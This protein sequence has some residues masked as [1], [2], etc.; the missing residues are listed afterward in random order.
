MISTI[1]QKMIFGVKIQVGV[2][3]VRFLFNYH[4]IN[5][6]NQFDCFLLIDILPLAHGF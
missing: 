4:L 5:L 1:D 3:I 6:L 2:F